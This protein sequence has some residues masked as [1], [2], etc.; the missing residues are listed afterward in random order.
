MKKRVFAL[1]LCLLLCLSILPVGAFADDYCEHDIVKMDAKT[2]CGEAYK[3]HFKCTKCGKLFS[4][5]RGEHEISYT[6]VALDKL[7][8]T[9]D[10]KHVEPKDATCTEPGNYEYW[11]CTEC[12]QM[13]SS[14]PGVAEDGTDNRRTCPVP[15]DKV[16]DYTIEPYGHN[17][18]FHEA[19]PHTCFENGNIAYY[20]C[21]NCWWSFTDPDAQ[22][23]VGDVTDPAAHVKT[24]YP[25][26]ARTCDTDGN[27]YYFYCE[28]CGKYYDG[29]EQEIT[30]G[31]WVIPAGHDYVEQ[32]FKEPTCTAE[33]NRLYYTC[34]ACGKIF[35]ADLNETTLE[36]VTLGMIPHSLVIHVPAAAKTCWDNG[37]VEYWQCASCGA[38]FA[39]AEGTLPL[40]DEE[41][42]IP[43]CHEFVATP[44]KEA[45]CTEPGNIA[46]W[47]CTVEG[48]G[49]VVDE[50]GK[51]VWET[52]VPAKGHV[53]QLHEAREASCTEDGNE[54]Y[55]SCD[56]CGKLFRLD[57]VTETSLE[58]VTI[59]KLGHKLGDLVQAVEPTCTTDGHIAYYECEQ[60]R[61]KFADAEG[62]TALAEDEI[63]IPKRHELKAH[64]A[65]AAT[66]TEPG[67]IA[68]S[69]CKNCD[70]VLNENG[71]Q[72]WLNDTIIPAPGHKPEKVK[73]TASCT[74]AGYAEHF[75]CSTCGKLFRD[76]AC[77]EETTLDELTVQALG[78]DYDADG[79]CTRCKAVSPEAPA[80]HP[81][82][83][84]VP[85]NDNTYVVVT[86]SAP[87][88]VFPANCQLS[89]QPV[90][91]VDDQTKEAVDAQRQEGAT[92]AK[93]FTYDIKVFK[94]GEE[95][96]PAD[97]SKVKVSFALATAANENLNAT[98]Y[99]V[100]EADD[101]TKT[102]EALETNVEDVNNEKAVVVETD[103]FSQ[104]TLEFTYN[105]LQY[106][107]IGNKS[108][109]IKTIL[110]TFPDLHF[111]DEVKV[112][113]VR[114]SNPELFSASKDVS[115]EWIVVSHKAFQ[116]E[117]RMIVKLVDG[118]G[119]IEEYDIKVTDA[120]ATVKVKIN[121]G[122]AS[123]AVNPAASEITVTMTP[124]TPIPVTITATPVP[125]GKTF[126]KWTIVSGIG[127]TAID[128]L[129]AATAHFSLSDSQ[130]SDKV[131]VTANNSNRVTFEKNTS[132]A[133]T[134]MP[135][136]RFVPDGTVIKSTDLSTP[137]AEGY[138]FAGWYEADG[139]TPVS[140]P[141]TINS[142]KTLYAK[143]QCRVTFDTLHGT[144]PPAQ[145]VDINAKATQPADMKWIGYT[146]GGW[147][148][149]KAWTNA[150]NFNTA[151][152]RNT[153]LYARWIPDLKI[154]KG[155][156]GTAHYG[157]TYAFT[158]NY[159]FHDYVENKALFNVAVGRHNSS[160]ATWVSKD[161][162]VVTQGAD[163]RAVVTL[164][165]SYIRTLTDGATYDIIF[166]TGLKPYEYDAGEYPPIDL[167]AT[168]GT[169]KVSKSPKTGDE[170]NVA[171]WAAIA[172]VS[173][174]AVVV[175]VAVLF[176]KRKKG[177]KAPTPPENRPADKTKKPPKE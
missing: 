110:K 54:A 96:Q 102:A 117:E 116:S 32:P 100:T 5:D 145:I 158:L 154:T 159:Y 52:V 37:N 22:N 2:T 35:D 61:E 85:N 153:V 43:A 69:T 14:N 8:H 79:W 71:D 89:V 60:C 36:A 128:D 86:V 123:T 142:N 174:I 148:T 98:V 34:S 10:L 28:V 3:A 164:K 168:E 59:P 109:N 51:Q 104:Y 41:V 56:A 44:A 127:T 111:S 173:L 12:G 114:V 70:I 24:E 1:L 171:L 42:V 47:T 175:I 169:F 137:S 166:D 81:Q 141:L 151:I 120:P 91:V 15:A 58:E 101:G 13:F 55:Y 76:A 105:D 39:D 106:V 63:V 84:T 50:S 139:K 90:F 126:E 108:V 57:G 78:H 134:N 103:G 112:I 176:N 143:W 45:T 113:D 23:P 160:G 107:L 135:A 115:G 130:V 40:T 75:M 7:P 31:S 95:I 9:S 20:Q 27:S 155:D 165:A 163:K 122:T 46:Y 144:T 74:E 147:Y 38:K 146:W 133:V 132:A 129:N 88:G 162:Y 170:S 152:T 121:G 25:A 92:V 119:E 4:D 138:V 65:K 150:F 16:K 156:G 177:K 94:N 124:G 33:G 64:P 99:H 6:D 125:S 136:D 82:P 26:V 87:E 17:L 19:V 157:S 62:E 11:L 18:T 77:T 161:H 172:G 29:N 53:F 68:Y 149:D 48:C 167:G 93:S 30:E 73:A 49:I 118:S 140:F 67:N 97:G 131:E 66:C 83:V 72:I 21:S 80:F